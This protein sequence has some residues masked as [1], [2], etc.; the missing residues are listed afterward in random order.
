MH[1]RYWIAIG[2]AAAAGSFAGTAWAEE[3]GLEGRD[4]IVL[5]D[6]LILRAPAAALALAP[7]APP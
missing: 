7:A 5:Q 1:A 6:G 2:L 3:P 4:D